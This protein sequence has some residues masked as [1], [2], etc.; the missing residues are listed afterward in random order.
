MAKSRL[1]T[2][3]DQLERIIDEDGAPEAVS[4]EETDPMAP[5]MP[6][7]TS[8]Q[9]NRDQEDE[10]VEFAM[11][12]L[13]ELENE[14]GRSRT[15]TGDWWL[16]G[17]RD[18]EQE[19]PQGVSRTE[20]TWMGK[21][22]LY[23]LVYQNDVE[24]RSSILGGI[25]AESNLVVPLARKI[26]RQMTAR[27]V[28]YY[29][30]TDPWFAMYPV[31]DA[32]KPRADKADR[33]SRWKFEQSHLKRR[34][35]LGIERAFVLGESVLKSTLENRVQVYKTTASVLVDETGADIL[36]ADGDY[37]LENDLW[38]EQVV[39]DPETGEPV[40]EAGFVLKRDGQTPRP[41][42]PI[43]VE[44]L[45]ERRMTMFFGPEANI[46]H[47][48]DFL[49]PLDAPSVQEADCVVHLY[50]MP[51]MTLADQWKK[52]QTARGGATEIAE[53]RKAI[54]LI[55]ELAQESATPKNAN[56]GYE[57]DLDIETSSSRED[58]S[59]PVASI[60][61]FYLR[62]DA[63]G[64]GMMEEIM[65][66]VDRTS[67]TPIF[68]DYT[69]N[70]TADGQRPFSVQRVNEVPGRWYGIGAME[71]FETT[72]QIIDL[73]VNRWNFSQSRSAR[74]DFWNPQNTLEGRSNPHLT[75]NWGGTYTPVPGKTAR[76]CLESVYL[77]NNKDGALQQFME[78][79]IQLA[80]N[81]S[82]VANAN[83]SKFAGLDSAE[84][85]TGVRNI[86]KSGQ[87]L[88]S[89]YLG[90]L[91]PGIS[92]LLR[93]QVNI[94]FANLNE[95][96]VYRYFEQGE[97]NGEGAEGVVEIDPADIADMDLDVKILLT[98]YRGE[99]IMESS[100]RATEL[101]E[102]FYSQH[103]F[104]QERTA[105]LYRQMLKALQVSNVDQ[106]IVP[107]PMNVMQTGPLDAAGM[108]GAATT[109]PRKSEPNL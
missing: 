68:Y 35:E 12:R 23:D 77:E 28:N 16:R 54:E 65:L 87:E 52:E 58:R 31:G 6:F 71:M 27:A 105:D 85:A 4:P 17:E 45:I 46:V 34:M 36:G 79:F 29:F 22:R 93:K 56:S 62:Y 15:G 47:F 67:K 81:E 96:E 109:Q 97:E 41:L 11:K 76:D 49:C 80:T 14:T 51:V 2:M 37:I 5:R 3:D 26:T 104:V 60:A 90:H 21:R 13:E 32:D 7:P 33:Y 95:M 25:F 53:T 86:E 20:R 82:G 72:Q 69:A 59:D 57:T 101:V 10:L 83:D 100:V 84:L 108:A 42:N 24:H 9:L 55:R 107:I 74:V 30:A 40:G 61:E 99:Q 8:Y 73:T 94:L 89:L 38:V 92:D 19:D 18:S 1:T 106:I 48:L 66:V 44:K 88:F 63:D 75:L 43:F 39:I 98:R 102:K 91:E 78:F 50:D 103:P 70:V 64:D